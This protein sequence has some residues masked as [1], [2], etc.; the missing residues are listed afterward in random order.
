MVMPMAM[1]KHGKRSYSS[2]LGGSGRHPASSSVLNRLSRELQVYFIFLSLFIFERERER[3]REG[4]RVSREG[5][6]REG[7]TGSEAGFRFG[8]VT[9]KPDT[10]LELTNCE[11]LT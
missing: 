11:I 6:E 8:A 4:P 7:D 10:G 3:E 1:G 2:F 5:A 9:T